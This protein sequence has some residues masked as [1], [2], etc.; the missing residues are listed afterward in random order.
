MVGSSAPAVARRAAQ[1]K[2]AWPGAGER[3]PQNGQTLGRVRTRPLLRPC[4]VSL[5]VLSWC[6]THLRLISVAISPAEASFTTIWPRTHSQSGWRVNGTELLG[7]RVVFQYQQAFWCG[8]ASGP[9]S[10]PARTW[11]RRNGPTTTPARVSGK[12]ATDPH[13]EHPRGP[14]GAGFNQNWRPRF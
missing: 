9:R 3:D 2:T 6:V 1:R 8:A 4:D 5:P 11:P 10:S 13:L 14:T 12:L 7:G